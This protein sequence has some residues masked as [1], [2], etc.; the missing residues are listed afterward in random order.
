ML[1]GLKFNVNQEWEDFVLLY[2]GSIQSWLLHFGAKLHDVDDIK[3]EILI[4][5]HSRLDSFRHNGRTGA[6]R[7]WLRQ[8]TYNRF[9]EHLKKAKRSKTQEV[10]SALVELTQP[11]RQKNSHLLASRE[12]GDLCES[13]LRKLEKR[14]ETQS[15]SVFRETVLRDRSTK[16]VAKELGMSEVATRVAKSRVLRAF[17]EVA[18]GTLK[19]Q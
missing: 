3:Q 12:F 15:I 4:F 13:C 9:R 2:S 19:V 1:E 18:R 17:L 6:F 11:Y 10:E 14:F 16:D 5:V 7:R 8:V